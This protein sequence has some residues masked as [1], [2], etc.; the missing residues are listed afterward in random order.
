MIFHTQFKAYL[1][2]LEKT[3]NEHWRNNIMLKDTDTGMWETV[4]GKYA[5]GMKEWMLSGAFYQ[6]ENSLPF[7]TSGIK[8]NEFILTLIF[9]SVF[10]QRAV[11]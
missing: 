10:P 4:E 2:D 9:Q 7:Q 6:W 5:G 11:L 1:C 3:K 8:K